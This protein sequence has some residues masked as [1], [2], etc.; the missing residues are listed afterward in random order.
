MTRTIL[1][2][3]LAAIFASPLF[4]HDVWVETNTGLIRAGDRVDIDLKLGNHGNNHR[5]FKQ[6][7]KVDPTTLSA[8]QVIDPTGKKYDLLPS[9]ADIGYAPK[10]GYFTAPFVTAVDGHY[11]VLAMGDKV[12]NHGT[13]LRSIRSAKTFFLASKSLDKPAAKTKNYSQPA[14]VPFELVLN[15]D[16]VLFNAPG[17]P[18]EVQLLLNGKPCFEEIVSFIPRGVELSSEFDKT[19]E[20]RTNEEGKAS[21]TPKEG[22]V[23]LIVAHRINETEK[24]ADYDGTKYTATLT[25]R[26]PQVCPCCDE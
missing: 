19:Y 21:F 26:V 17:K 13:P 15:S 2:V 24:G 6:A 12:V 8:V 4:A 10:E 14:G 3:L 7:G 22:N 5:D 1:T 23:F 18:I 16:P 25:I 9:L 11:M 20:R